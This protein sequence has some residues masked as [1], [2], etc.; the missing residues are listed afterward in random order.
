[1]NGAD[2]P[3]VQI[4][5]RTLLDLTISAVADCAQVVIVGPDHCSRPGVVTITE[6]PPFGG[7]VAALAAGLSQLSDA[8]AQTWVLACDQ[9]RSAQI[10][11]LLEPIEIPDDADAVI[12]QDAAGRDQP[13]AGRY[14]VAALRAVIGA[15]GD[16]DGAAMRRLGER[17]RI[18]RVPDTAHASIDLDTWADVEEYRRAHDRTVRPE[19]NQPMSDAP[20]QLD[21]WAAEVARALNIPGDVPVAALLSVTRDVAHGVMRPAGPVST[22]LIGHAIAAGMSV[23]DA[24]AVVRAYIPEQA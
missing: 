22:Y 13:L 9:P 18:V 24:L 19:R 20:S 7:P 3:H 17:L 16:V 8:A 4:D 2:K 21:S 12:L 6:Q 15:L 5:E 1:M 23:D 11:A 14:R 10:V